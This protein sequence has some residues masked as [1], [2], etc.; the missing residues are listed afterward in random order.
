MKLYELHAQVLSKI[1]L[2]LGICFSLILAVGPFK[3]TVLAQEWTTYTASGNDLP[4]G[5]VVSIAQDSDGIMWIVNGKLEFIDFVGHV[6][7]YDGSWYPPF[8]EPA[9]VVFADRDGAM[10]VGTERSGIYLYENHNGIWQLERNFTVADGLPINDVNSIFQDQEGVMWFG[11]G[12]FPQLIHKGVG[13]ARYDRQNEEWKRYTTEG[14]SRYN[15]EIGDWIQL[16][17]YTPEN[18]LPDNTVN[19]IVQD[20]NGDLWVGTPQGASR[21]DGSEWHTYLSTNKVVS[22]WLARDGAIWAADGSLTGAG[23]S[24][25]EEQNGVWQWVQTYTTTEGLVDNS[26]HDMLQA[27]DGTFW[28]ATKDGVSQFD[29][30]NW[31]PFKSADGLA[32]NWTNRIFESFDGAIWIGTKNGLSRYEPSRWNAYPNTQIKWTGGNEVTSIF[33]DRDGA[34]WIGSSGRVP[35]IRQVGGENRS[36]P[37]PFERYFPVRAII[38]DW[39]GN[40]WFGSHRGGLGLIRLNGEDWETIQDPYIDNVPVTQAAL[41]DP[42]DVFMD[43]ENNLYIVDEGD[44]RIRKVDTSGIITTVAGNGIS[45][46]SGDG[47]PATEASFRQFTEVVLDGVGNLYIFDEFDSRIR[48]VDAAGIITTVAGN[49]KSGFSEDGGPATEASLGNLPFTE[50]FSSFFV[51]AASNFRLEN[52]LPEKY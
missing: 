38:Q 50:G 18:G 51:D 29:G 46:F 2:C 22:L 9:L 8:E 24:R 30:E 39:D 28:F 7:L 16:E 47:G 40:M 33:Q 41:A 27:S 35:H 17:T 14:V 13:L 15:R 37:Y 10:W 20:R 6:N 52:C 4:E 23:V 44:L 26:V 3:N 49:G 32:D 48:K 45:G 11:T 25:F 36:I 43:S 21:F 34:L 19:A 1:Q 12:G 31:R 5:F 42:V